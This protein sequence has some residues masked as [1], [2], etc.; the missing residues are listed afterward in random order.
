MTAPLHR[1]ARKKRACCIFATICAFD[2]S[3][4]DERFSGVMQM[5]IRSI[6]LASAAIAGTPI[7]TANA[8]DLPAAIPAKAR[9]AVPSFGWTGFYV[10]A[11]VGGV[12]TD[13][14]MIE[15]D[16]FQILPIPSNSI[17]QSS[18]I[19]GVQAGYNWQ[20]SNIVLG[21][22]ADFDFA[23][24]NK[25][26]SLGSLAGLNTH[27]SRLS[28]LATVRGRLGMAFDRLLAYATGGAAFARLKNEV[29]NT[30]FPFTAS[31]G[32]STTGWTIGGGLEYAISNHWTFK[33][34]YLYV[35]FP[36]KAVVVPTPAPYAFA[37]EDSASIARVGINYKF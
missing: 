14:S 36:D 27:H 17:H 13:S 19:G 30:G 34:E 29:I 37:F 33:V 22:E 21:L 26:V 20:I 23:S 4:L 35:A 25:Q 10:G 2:F 15:T 9:M 24:A 18:L 5:K 31:R 8:A 32:N 28:T 11:N 3:K 6:L 16:P 7:A 1:R 12:W